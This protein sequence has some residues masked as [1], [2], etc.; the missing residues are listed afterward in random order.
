M[1]SNGCQG[2]DNCPFHVSTKNSIDLYTFLCNEMS[3]CLARPMEI[4]KLSAFRPQQEI[5]MKLMNEYLMKILKITNVHHQERKLKKRMA[6][7][8]MVE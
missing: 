8:K 7:V 5:N 4:S 1:I 2:V 3:S 6:A